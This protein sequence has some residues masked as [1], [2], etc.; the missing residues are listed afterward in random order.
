MMDSVPDKG[1]KVACDRFL[2]RWTVTSVATIMSGLE[3][4]LDYHPN[5]GMSM[6]QHVTGW[7]DLMRKLKKWKVPLTELPV[8]ESMLFLRTLPKKYGDF[9]THKKPQEDTLCNT[10]VLYEAATAWGA[11]VCRRDNR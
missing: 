4:A 2:R 11:N 7:Q 5:K 1:G 9:I 10:A 8:L 3:G 6:A